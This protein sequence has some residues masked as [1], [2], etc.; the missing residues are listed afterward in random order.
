MKPLVNSVAALT[1]LAATLLFPV[2]GHAAPATPSMSVTIVSASPTTVSAKH[3]TVTFQL[4]IKGLVLDAMHMG[5]TNVRG[6][7]HIQLYVDSI[8]SDAYIRK[9]FQH[10]WLAS[11]ATTTISLN[12]SPALVGGPG[13]HK[14]IVALAQNNYVLY[15]VPTASVAITVK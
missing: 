12:L 8:A 14:I 2:M 1:I 6:R 3:A 13:K 4:R 11:L 10:H 9:D 7:G 5:K 15:H